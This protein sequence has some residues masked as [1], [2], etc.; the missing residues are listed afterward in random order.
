LVRDAG[1]LQCN[2]SDAFAKRDLTDHAKKVLENVR[3]SCRD[4][5]LETCAYE[6]R[7]IIYEVL[8]CKNNNQ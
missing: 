4:D 2:P 7:T 3:L 5:I 1:N 8:V 6:F